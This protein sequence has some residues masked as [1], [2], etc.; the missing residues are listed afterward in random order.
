MAAPVPG[1]GCIS[2]NGVLLAWTRWT[3]RGMAVPDAVYE[4]VM[5]APRGT[6][7]QELRFRE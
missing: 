4:P 6:Y 1:A 7:T 2:I 5:G 3:P